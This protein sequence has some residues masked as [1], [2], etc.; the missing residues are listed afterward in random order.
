MSNWSQE[1]DT[2]ALGASGGIEGDTPAPLFPPP[3]SHWNLPLAKPSLKPADWEP[4][5]PGS[6][7]P[8]TQGRE[9]AGQGK[10]SPGMAQG[11]RMVALRHRAHERGQDMLPLPSFGPT[12]NAHPTVL[13][14][15]IWHL[16]SSWCLADKCSELPPPARSIRLPVAGCV[17]RDLAHQELKLPDKAQKCSLSQGDV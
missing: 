8:V 13:E 2:A 7:P 1:Q 15:G 4:G 9:E 16:T 3:M 14:A 17:A 10:D 5:K 11:V 12:P 6:Q